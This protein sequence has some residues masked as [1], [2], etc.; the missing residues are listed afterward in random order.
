MPPWCNCTLPYVTPNS[1]AQRSTV[2]LN[3]SNTNSNPQQREL[4]LSQPPKN[5]RSHLVQFRWEARTQEATTKKTRR[6]KKATDAWSH[7]HT[8][9]SYHQTIM[10]LAVKNHTSKGRDSEISHLSAQRS[11][12]EQKQTLNADPTWYADTF[13]RLVAGYR[14]LTHKLTC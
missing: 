9:T 4:H 6:E 10:K 8:D 3:N 11:Q 5:T 7:V 14:G 12:E 2:P 1:E 13:T